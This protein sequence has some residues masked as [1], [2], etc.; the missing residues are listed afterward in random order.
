VLAVPPAAAPYRASGL[1]H[2]RKADVRA[3]QQKLSS[4]AW[5]LNLRISINGF[6]SDVVVE[7][8]L[9]LFENAPDAMILG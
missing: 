6:A 1:V 4:N 7:K 5:L 8:A 9:R 2:W 3:V